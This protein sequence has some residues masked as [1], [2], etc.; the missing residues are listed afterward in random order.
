M[1]LQHNTLC[2]SILLVLL[3]GSYL[4]VPKMVFAEELPPPPKNINDINQLFKLYL[5]LVVN[6]YAIQQVVPVVVKN[7]EYFIQKKK[8]VDELEISIPEEMLSSSNETVLTDKDILTLGFS[9]DAADWISLDRLKDVSY[10]YNSSNQYFQLNIPPAWMPTQILGKDSWYKPETA[11]SG[12]GLLNNY[13]FYTYRPS[14]GG[15]TSSLFTEQRFFSPLGVIKNSGVYVKN[16]FKNE[17]GIESF[18]NDG[19]RRYDTSWQFDSQKSATSFLFGDIITGNKTTWGSSVRLGGFQV[20]RN[21]STRPD[22]ITYPLPQFIGQAA[23]PSTVDLIINGQKASSTDVQS[24]PFILNNVPFI[25]GKGEAVVV[26][27]DAVGRQVTTAVPFYISNTLLKPGLFDYSLSLGNIREDYGLKNFSYGKFASAADARYGVNDW[28]TVEGRTELSS[29]LQLLGAGS[30][31]KLANLGVL[32]A[33]FTQSRADKSMAQDQVKDLDGKQYTIGYSYNR[34]RFGFSI[35]HNQRDDEYTDLSRMQYSNLISVNSNKSLTANTYFATRKSGT[36]GVGY[37]N[38]EANDFKN[39]L[40]NLSWAPILPAYMSGVTVSL[41]ANRDFVEKEWSAAF[42]VSVPLFQRKSSVNTGYSF[43]DHGD[44][45]YI[46]FN[47]SVPSE[48]GFGVD[49]TRRFNENSE[50]LNQ[51]RVNYRNNYINTDF[52][53]SGNHDYNYWFGLSGSLVY[54]SG[55]L[56]AS[57]RLGESFALVDTNKVAD[58][59]VKYENSLIGRSNKKGHIFVPSVTPYYSGKY[60]VDPI[61]LPSNFTITQVEQRIAAKRGSGVVIKFPVQESIAAN[62]YLTQENGKPISVGS[63]VHRD[64]QESS[65]VGMDGIVYLENLKANNTITVQHSDQSICKADFTVDVEQAKQQIV[66]VKPVICH[67]VSL[68]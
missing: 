62:V 52:G 46:N 39:E 34:N 26:T 36:F 57:N 27:T 43:N 20:Q 8:L 40:L 45:G 24:G 30:V 38:T 1:I 37:I 9:G 48:G 16:Q 29:D 13:D 5:D 66:V 60:S 56:F 2:K 21:Y 59:L 32:S 68:P 4:S 58:V 54:M 15:S 44:Y 25:N 64:D 7:D 18:N 50:D 33:S 11:Q 10:E 41:S 23:L 53:L 17:E 63:V 61:D 51:A 65:Y 6:K 12:I 19:Y 42:Q 22:L 14:Q 55:D 3:A 47:H 28:F 49:L 31:L 67:E 35:N